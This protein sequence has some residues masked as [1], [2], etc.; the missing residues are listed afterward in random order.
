MSLLLPARGTT[1]L[2]PARGARGAGSRPLYLALA[3]Q[4]ELRLF[5]DGKPM[6]ILA[7]E[8][9]AVVAVIYTILV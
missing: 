8:T 7:D 2:A 6:P 9:S 4:D 1:G 5:V 3:P